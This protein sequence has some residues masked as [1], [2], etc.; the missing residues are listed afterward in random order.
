MRILVLLTDAFGG[1][2]GIALYN[3][4]LIT[5]L[6]SYPDCAEVVAVPRIMPRPSEPRPEKLTYVTSGLNSKRG[7]VKAV[8]ETVRK[9]SAFDL[10]ICGH[11]NLLP[12]AF[13]VRWWLRAPLLL[14]IYGI[15]AWKRTRSRLLN[16]LVKRID[17][18]VSIS[19]ITR[20]RFLSWT[21]LPAKK[22]FVLPNAIHK[23]KYSPGPKSPEL[24]RRY[25]LKGKVVLMTMGRLVSK[26]RYKG[27]DEVMNV[28]PALIQEL[29]DVEYLVV[30]S[31]DDRPRLQKKARDIP[32][33]HW[34]GR[35]RG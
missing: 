31:G 20:S 28:L 11:I 26:E 5:A 34:L 21:M 7:F 10:I 8:W 22:G 23:E 15:D 2:G 24:M 32:S 13:A 29:P 33:R 25:G 35:N 19:E 9:N 17:A 16:G 30:G 6:C 12:I 3:R 18:F 1:H 4:D 14:E 27:F